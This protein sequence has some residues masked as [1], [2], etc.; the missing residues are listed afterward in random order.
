MGY[1]QRCEPCRRYTAEGVPALRRD[2]AG[3]FGPQG[4]LAYDNARVIGQQYGRPAH[5]SASAGS[6][7]TRRRTG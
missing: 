3:W 5:R 2:L 4:V 7:S 1:R 6:W